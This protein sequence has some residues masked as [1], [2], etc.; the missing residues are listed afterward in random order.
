VISLFVV[1][2]SCAVLLCDLYLYFSV[3]GIVNIFHSDK[4]D[5]NQSDPEKFGLRPAA[6]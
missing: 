3:G 6:I 2:F 1:I 5:S 4:D